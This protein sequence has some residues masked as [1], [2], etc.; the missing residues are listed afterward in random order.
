MGVGINI[1][2]SLKCLGLSLE[3]TEREIKV[4]FRQLSRTYHPDKHKPEQTG[5]TQREATEKFQLINN[6]YSYLV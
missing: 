2:D 4:S 6:A 1:T 5:L 3:A